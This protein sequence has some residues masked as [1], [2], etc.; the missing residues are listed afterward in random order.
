MGSKYGASSVSAVAAWALPLNDLSRHGGALETISDLEAMVASNPT[1]TPPFATSRRNPRHALE[2]N[3]FE[4]SF[5]SNPADAEGNDA[6]GE[7]K[8]AASPSPRNKSGALP[9]PTPSKVAKETSNKKDENGAAAQKQGNAHE[10]HHGPRLPS[11]AAL[12]S[13]SGEGNATTSYPWPSSL[14]SLR[15]GPLSPAMLAGPAA[16]NGNGQNSGSA[17]DVSAYRTGFTP[18]L[19]NFKTGLTPVGSGGAAFPPPSPGTAAFL[20]MITHGG[21]PGLTPGTLNALTGANGMQDNG[22]LGAQQSGRE[23]D[24]FAMAFQQSMGHH[25]TD[26]AHGAKPGSRLRPTSAEAA[27][28]ATL[29]PDQTRHAPEGK[30]SKRGGEQGG[31][32]TKTTGGGANNGSQNGA[33]DNAA[34]GLFLLSQ[35]H[36]E[37]AKREDEAA[38]AAA[39]ALSGAN[40]HQNGVALPKKGS[41]NKRKNTGGSSSGRGGGKKAKTP[42]SEAGSLGSPGPGSDDEMEEFDKNGEPLDDEEKRKNFLERNRQAALKCRQRKKAWLQQLQQRAEMLQN[43]NEH[44]RD[45]IGAL[46]GEIAFL[47][48]QL[49]AAQAQLAGGLPPG[50]MGEAGGPVHSIPG[51]HGVIP[52]SAAQGGGLPPGVPLPSGLSMNM[53]TSVHPAHIAGVGPGTCQAHAVPR[54]THIPDLQPLKTL[55]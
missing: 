14:G 11:V 20:A 30:K 38:T 9:A 8:A 19:S 42:H 33:S 54:P 25:G 1:L 23:G 3:P 52:V 35:A 49:M 26:G 51:P 27:S 17:F 29:N 32:K 28:G 36:Q 55:A 44:L 40:S 37:L 39:H 5:G 2:P 47:K 10:G 15:A 43:D 22:H 6:G 45:N 46:R 48:T 13:P 31:I 16:A 4:K 24:Q 12:T 53:N 41:G 7:E 21:G 34:S 18:D 50:S